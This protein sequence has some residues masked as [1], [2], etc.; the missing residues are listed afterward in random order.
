VNSEAKGSQ[1]NKVSKN[2]LKT[3][4]SNLFYN[5][6]IFLFF[7]V[8]IAA[9]YSI[10]QKITNNEIVK[11]DLQK[12]SRIIQVEILNASGV[13]GIASRASD[14]LRDK[15]IDVVKIGNYD[16][17]LID[18]TIIIDRSGNKANAKLIGKILGINNSNI[19]EQLNPELVID[20]TVILGLDY[21]HLNP[22]K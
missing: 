8:F 18:K 4:L 14:Y 5:I 6:A 15:N 19:V 16:K 12:P 7:V 22:F 10:F 11:D 13:S 9:G 20:V 3:S 2:N 17:G 1:K 21:E